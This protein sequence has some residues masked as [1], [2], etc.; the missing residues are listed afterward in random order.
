MHVMLSGIGLIMCVVMCIF[1]EIV[2][3]YACLSKNE[4]VGVALL[5]WLKKVLM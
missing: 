5:F 2:S 3:V 4:S 1:F